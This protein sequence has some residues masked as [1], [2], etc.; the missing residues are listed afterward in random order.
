MRLNRNDVHAIEWWLLSVH[1]EIGV[2]LRGLHIV[3]MVHGLS[4]SGIPWRM[5]DRSL[6]NLS[7][8]HSQA[9]PHQQRSPI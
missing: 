5:G 1:P 8:P 9:F 6:V 4:R 7:G 3:H 2:V